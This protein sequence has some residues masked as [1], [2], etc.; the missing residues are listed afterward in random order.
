MYSR[1]VRLVL[2][3][4]LL[5]ATG[6]ASRGVFAQDVTASI[7]GFVTDNAGAAVSGANVTV[8]NFATGEQRK[9]TT[10]ETGNTPCRV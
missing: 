4:A 9:T 3:V 5:L 7:S 2:M 1:I 10:D 8:V 6:G